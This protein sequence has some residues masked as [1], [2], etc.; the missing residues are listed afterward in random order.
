MERTIHWLGLSPILFDT[1]R[2]EMVTQYTSPKMDPMTRAKLQK[3]FDPYNKRFY[4]LMGPEWQNIWDALF[5]RFM[6]VHRDFFLKNPRLGMLIRTFDKWDDHK[7]E[8][9]L[10]VANNYIST[11]K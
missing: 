1:S 7:R 2:R 4:K 5:W 6:H 8:N 11:L 10:A 9:I 3:F